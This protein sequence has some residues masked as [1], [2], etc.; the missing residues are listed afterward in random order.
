M[1]ARSHSRS[2]SPAPPTDFYAGLGANAGAGQMATAGLLVGGGILQEGRRGAISGP[3][4]SY[5]EGKYE[6]GNLEG[7]SGIVV[8]EEG[9]TE[10]KKKK[11][12]E[13]KKE[14]KEENEK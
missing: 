2:A 10:K 3:S 4:S 5:Y 6:R 7:R 11:G 8:P 14:K 12:E 13:K 1:R 9:R